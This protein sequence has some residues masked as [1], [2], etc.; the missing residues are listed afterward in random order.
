MLNKFDTLLPQDFETLCFHDF[1]ILV[2]TLVAKQGFGAPA[3][4]SHDSA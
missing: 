2:T 1:Y 3:A 4:A